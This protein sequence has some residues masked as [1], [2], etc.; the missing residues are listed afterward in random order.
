MNEKEKRELTENIIAGA[1]EAG[2]IGS[3]YG[4]L[5]VA[6]MPIIREVL[7]LIISKLSAVEFVKLSILWTKAASVFRR[8]KDEEGRGRGRGLE[9]ES[10]PEPEPA[11]APAQLDWT[12]GGDPH[13]ILGTYGMTFPDVAE[14]PIDFEIVKISHDGIWWTA[15]LSDLD[16]FKAYPGDHMEKRRGVIYFFRDGTLIGY[17]DCSGG[18]NFADARIG[19]HLD[20]GATHVMIIHCK[21]GRMVSRTKLT[22]V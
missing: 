1:I 10:K 8:W 7:G 18:Y 22:D 15:P 2:L 21:H 6:L 20:N 3:K 19:G 16:G 13:D 11:P 4:K 14:L 12:R 5:A 9:P 17:E